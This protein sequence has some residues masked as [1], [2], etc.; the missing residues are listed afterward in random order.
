MP[1]TSLLCRLSTKTPYVFIVQSLLTVLR[2]SVAVSLT[3]NDLYI[4]GRQLDRQRLVK[5]SLAH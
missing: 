2:I 1:R 3:V 5:E 4:R